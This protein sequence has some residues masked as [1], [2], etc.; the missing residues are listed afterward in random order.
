MTRSQEVKRD[1]RI[2]KY[3]SHGPSCPSADSR[4]R[5]RL[6]ARRAS[7]AGDDHQGSCPGVEEWRALSYEAVH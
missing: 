1:E 7:E 6:D 2:R 4:V 3:C 5:A